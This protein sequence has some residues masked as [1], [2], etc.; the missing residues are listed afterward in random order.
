M[1]AP[2]NSNS[3]T[4]LSE[5]EIQNQGYDPVF[6]VP[7][8]EVIGHHS[9]SNSI[10]RIQTR[11]DGTLAFGGLYL[12]DYDYIGVTYPDTVTETYTYKSGGSSGSTVAVV[13]VVFTNSTKEFISSL[14]RTT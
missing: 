8:A 7:V 12:P 2:D 14:E 11:E 4:K 3:W 10:K 9:G 13:T 5:Q 1:A 6:G